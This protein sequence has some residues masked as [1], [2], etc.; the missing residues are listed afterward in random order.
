MCL[1]MDTF[2]N[3]HTQRFLFYIKDFQ[4]IAINIKNGFKKELNINLFLFINKNVF[5]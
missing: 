1:K 2:N 4:D 5:I 3:R